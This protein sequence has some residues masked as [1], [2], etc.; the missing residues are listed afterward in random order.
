MAMAAIR[1]PT[2][3]MYQ[4]TVVMTYPRRLSTV[5][6]TSVPA[7]DGGVSPLGRGTGMAL[8]FVDG[9]C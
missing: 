3:P 2:A 5:A 6:A 4:R 8:R 7:V 1:N 9:H